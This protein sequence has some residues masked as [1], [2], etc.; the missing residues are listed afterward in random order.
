V[1]TD[2]ATSRIRE[3]IVGRF[4]P[5][6]PPHQLDD[7]FDLLKNGVVNSLDLLRLIAWLG[8]KFEIPVDDV[9]IAPDNFRS[10]R[11]IGEFIDSV[12]AGTGTPR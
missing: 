5:D 9:D 1:P 3:F 11:S 8:E 10:I 7:D 4:A 6:V 2:A 12:G